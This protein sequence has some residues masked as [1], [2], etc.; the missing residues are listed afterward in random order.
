MGKRKSE[1][2]N[3]CL[4]RL[5]NYY[6]K[7]STLVFGAENIVPVRDNEGTTRQE[8]ESNGGASNHRRKTG[9]TVANGGTNSVTS[10]P[11]RQSGSCRASCAR[12][13]PTERGPRRHF[14][15]VAR[16]SRYSAGDV[17]CCLAAIPMSESSKESLQVPVDGVFSSAAYLGV[18]RKVRVY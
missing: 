15:V 5:P 1:K 2:R 16:T 9:Q 7:R 14:R 17:S 6:G 11:S 8:R 10:R 18:T 12:P 4:G 13:T 3:V